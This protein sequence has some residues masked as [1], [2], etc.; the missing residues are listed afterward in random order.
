VRPFLEKADCF[1]F[2]SFYHEGIPRCL[3]EAA[4]MEVPIIT[5]EN[6]GCREVVKEGLNGFLCAPHNPQ[7]LS[8]RME[9][10]MKLD[11]SERRRLGV[12]GRLLVSERFG[13]DIILREY[14]RAVAHL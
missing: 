12:N 6:T 11:S 1:V 8:V 13:M 10:M 14:D 7:E 2:P 5:S 4:S 9:E 3:L